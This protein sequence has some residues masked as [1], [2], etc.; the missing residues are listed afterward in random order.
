MVG[1]FFQ[2]Y[3]FHYGKKYKHL[4]DKALFFSLW[5]QNLFCFTLEW[6]ICGLSVCERNKVWIPRF[7]YFFLGDYSY[8]VFSKIFFIFFFTFGHPT[9][10][11]VPGP[12]IRSVPVMVVTYATA[13]AAVLDVLTH[14]AKPGW[15]LNLHLGAAETLL[16]L[17][18]H[19]RNS[20]PK[21]FLSSDS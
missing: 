12:G 15:G 21:R 1:F 17:L 2:Y 3:N 13:A 10:Y 5:P 4:E 9:A 11:G 7:I 16:I 20:V 19:S 18:S 14:C 8:S 6:V